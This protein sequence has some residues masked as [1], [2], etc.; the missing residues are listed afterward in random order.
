MIR[1]KLDSTIG[2]KMRLQ[3]DHAETKIN[4][5]EKHINK[6]EEEIKLYQA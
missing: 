1:N 3:I 4:T 5:V 2:E 6:V